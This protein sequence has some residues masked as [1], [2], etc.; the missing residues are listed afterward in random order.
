[1][2]RSRS[3]DLL[4]ITS[5]PP[6]KSVYEGQTVAVGSYAKNTL[7][8]LLTHAKKQ[9]VGLPKIV[10]LAEKKE[11]EKV[12]VYNDDGIEVRRVWQ[13]NSFKTLLTLLREVLRFPL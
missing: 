6:K 13:Q 11:K 12:E 4:V 2:E 1:M 8:S 7:L 10:V 9:N 3:A 5:Y